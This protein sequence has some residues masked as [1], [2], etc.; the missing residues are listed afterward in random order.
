MNLWCTICTTKRTMQWNEKAQNEKSFSSS[1]SSMCRLLLRTHEISAQR[2]GLHLLLLSLP[3][4][5]SSFPFL[6]DCLFC[7][8]SILNLLLTLYISGRW[9]W[10]LFLRFSA[11]LWSS[12]SFSDPSVLSFFLPFW[13]CILP[14]SLYFWAINLASF[15][16][17][18]CLASRNRSCCSR[19]IIT[20][21]HKN[22]KG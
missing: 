21:N 18:F 7:L 3:P 13:L 12:S 11:S 16:S 2:T 1:P 9:T 4:S 8:S 22:K 10:L 20:E 5:S 19:A 6:F 17:I 15:P 14:Y